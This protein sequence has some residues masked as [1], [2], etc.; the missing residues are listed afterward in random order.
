MDALSDNA[1]LPCDMR[2]KATQAVQLEP[3]ACCSS[4]MP[5]FTK[6]GQHHQQRTALCWCLLTSDVV[7]QVVQE[8]STMLLQLPGKPCN[9]PAENTHACAL[10]SRPAHCHKELTHLFVM[11]PEPR[12]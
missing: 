6:Q 3:H 11:Q 4:C 10:L 2:H 12:A 8:T 9:L 5:K 1:T 7:M